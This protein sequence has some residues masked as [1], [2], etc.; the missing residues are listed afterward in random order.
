[1]FIPL[2]VNICNHFGDKLSS[3]SSTGIM[4]HF[5][6][7]PPSSTMVSGRLKLNEGQK[8]FT[9]GCSNLVTLWQKNCQEIPRRLWS[10]SLVDFLWIFN[11]LNGEC[12]EGLGVGKPLFISYMQGVFTKKQ[13]QR[14]TQWLDRQ[15]SSMAIQKIQAFRVA[16]FELRNSQISQKL[17]GSTF[18]G[19]NMMEYG[20][21]M[22][23]P[24]SS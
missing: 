5:L 19:G 22:I 23:Q 13:T 2:Q 20:Y 21:N 3:L 12:S 9:R 4:A 14:P 8:N 18:L 10:F 7:G 17:L 6:Y 24:Y 11:E 15:E 1:M 16:N